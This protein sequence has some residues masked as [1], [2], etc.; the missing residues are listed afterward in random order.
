MVDAAEQ[1]RG[2]EAWARDLVAPGPG[3][4][5]DQAVEAQAPQ[6]VG[7]PSLGDLAGREAQQGGELIAKLAVGEAAGTEPEEE[8]RQ[9]Q[10]LH[11]RISEAQASGALP[12]DLLGSLDALERVFAHR[13]VVAEAL[14]V[15]QT[16]VGGEA[17]LPQ[18][19][20]VVQP[21]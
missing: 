10:G 11:A 6:V 18:R 8:Q 12:A 3:D 17:D 2:L 9:E 1:Q 14:D 21:A 15:E 20:E 13:A 19:R 4:A 5:L 7:H 16:S